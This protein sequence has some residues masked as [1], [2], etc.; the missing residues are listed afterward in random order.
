MTPHDR[1]AQRRVELVA[2][3]AREREELGRLIGEV[4]APLQRAERM[5]DATGLLARRFAAWWIPAAAL[6]LVR[7]RG[8]MGF[9]FK[10]LPLYQLFRV[11]RRLTHEPD[12]QKSRSRTWERLSRA[13]KYPR[14]S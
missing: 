3:L 12:Q 13:S 1:R 6:L 4:A 11:F 10:A 9:A 14:A 2:Q 5:G 8:I 7:S